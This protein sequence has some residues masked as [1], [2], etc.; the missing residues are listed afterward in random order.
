MFNKALKTEYNELAL[1]EELAECI[2]KAISNDV[3]IIRVIEEIAKKD[4]SLTEHVRGITVDSDSIYG[5]TKLEIQENIVI[6]KK[7]DGK[8]HNPAIKKIDSIIAFL[9]GATMVYYEK[10]ADKKKRY[11]FT[12]RGIEVLEELEHQGYISTEK[13]GE[14][15]TKG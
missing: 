8:P 13:I 2:A 1:G 10:H 12:S 11:L 6:G 7:R 4:R 5:L 3:L 15:I 9:M 14:E